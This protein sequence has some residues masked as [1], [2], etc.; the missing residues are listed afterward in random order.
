MT[1]Y[2]T[3]Y[4]TTAL[5]GYVLGKTED[6]IRAAHG[7]G[8]FETLAPGLF[9][10][11]KSDSATDAIPAFGHPLLVS[12]GK[13]Q[14]DLFLDMRP[15]GKWDPHNQRFNIRNE[16]EYN[17]Q[18]LR[19]RLNLIWMQESPTLLRD[20]SQIATDVFASW[21]SENVVRRFAMD[22][23]EQK[24]L[25]VY[26]A[27]FYQCLFVDS[28]EELTDPVR[29]RMAA[30]IARATRIQAQE[31]LEVIDRFQTPLKGLGEFCQWMK[32][33][34]KS[35]RLTEM[36]PALLIQILGGTWF[37]SNARELVAVALEH[38][39]TWIAILYSAYNERT[40]KHSGIATIA[41]RG[42]SKAGRLFVQA[43]SNLVRATAE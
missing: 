11:E 35:V 26:A 4:N 7:Y 10:I 33:V 9:T 18:A 42:D 39:P 2:R 27:F 41:G 32:D 34:T 43:V 5:D 20:V 37:G 22:P 29:H 8:N 25:A 12:F 13:E 40:Y 3:A 15:Y 28:T 16:V 17:L 6:A 36:N 21:V 19:G 38:P 23:Q 30:T 1:V 31:V 24:T 14:T